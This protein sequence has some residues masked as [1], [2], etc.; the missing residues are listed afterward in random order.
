M[1]KTLV[2]LTTVGRVS[3]APRRANN[4]RRLPQTPDTPTNATSKQISFQP[5]I[6]F[7]LMTCEWHFCPEVWEREHMTTTSHTLRRG[8]R[9]RAEVSPRVLWL[10]DGLMDS[11]FYCERV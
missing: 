6:D 3:G 7:Q 1:P 4:E 10:A 8:R 9:Q 11:V 2:C 5:S